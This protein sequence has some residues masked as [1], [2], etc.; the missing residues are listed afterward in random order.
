MLFTVPVTLIV[1]LD[2]QVTYELF[3]FNVPLIINEQLLLLKL[4]DIP[5][6]TFIVHLM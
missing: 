1:V 6:S 4:K 2:E 5:D 3:P